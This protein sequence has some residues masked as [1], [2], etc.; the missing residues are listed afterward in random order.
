MLDHI[1]RKI[2][3]PA[4]TPDSNAEQ[5]DNV[6][7]RVLNHEQPAR[8]QTE[9]KEQETFDFNPAGIGDVF[10]EWCMATAGRPC[11]PTWSP[12]FYLTV[13]RRQQYSRLPPRQGFWMGDG[14][15]LH[16]TFLGDYFRFLNLSLKRQDRIKIKSGTQKCEMRKSL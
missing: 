13:F 12:P 16:F 14:G 11:E 2:I 9:N 15:T 4:K 6:K 3:E 8:Q 10:H 1:K 5:K 7:F